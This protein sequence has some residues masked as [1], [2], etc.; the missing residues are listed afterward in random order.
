MNHT[1]AHRR[2][3]AVGA[4]SLVVTGAGHGALV[5]VGSVTAP[6]VAEAEAR[7]VMAATEAVGLGLERSLSQL[8]LGFSV[9]M[10]LL[11]VAFG[12][13]NLLALRHA[14]QLFLGTDTVLLL[15]LA[16]VMIALVISAT[17]LPPPPIV[18]LAVATAAFGAATG[19]RRPASAEREPT[20]RPAPAPVG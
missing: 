6:P 14:P 15:D 10:A 5:V 17:L 20:S 13:L 11:L 16:V 9:T 7:R 4:W 19:L 12:V 1:L 18:L 8:F 2:S 3:I